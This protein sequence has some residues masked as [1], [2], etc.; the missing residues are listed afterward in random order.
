[1]TTRPGQ[2]SRRFRYNHFNSCFRDDGL[3]GERLYTLSQN[4]VVISDQSCLYN[5]ERP[6]GGVGYLTPSEAEGTGLR[7]VCLTLELT[8]NSVAGTAPA[9]QSARTTGGYRPLRFSSSTI[10]LANNSITRP[11]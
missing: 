5:E 9:C 7:P 2:G 3:N 4:R 8:I 10:K 6:H 11:K 1:M